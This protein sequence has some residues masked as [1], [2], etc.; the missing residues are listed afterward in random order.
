[1]NKVNT[2]KIYMTAT[3][4]KPLKEWN[5]PLECRMYWDIEDEQ[6]CKSMSLDKLKEKHGKDYVDKLILNKS[7]DDVF[8]CYE[9]MPDLHLITNMFD[10]EKYEIIKKKINNENKFG[11]CFN[12]LFGLNTSKTKFI[13]INE[14]KTILRY[15]SGSF[16]EQ[17][18]DKTIFT[19]IN[20]ICS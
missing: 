7:L 13:Y 11:F 14:V 1:M 20:N 10:S 5:I 12:T 4:N 2:V 15:I 17:D 16:R 18:G 3:Y 6:L 19:R 8:K 9:K